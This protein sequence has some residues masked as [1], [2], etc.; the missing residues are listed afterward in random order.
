MP[1]A[2]RLATKLSGRDSGA[3]RRG[4]AGRELRMFRTSGI[5]R[6]RGVNL[7]ISTKVLDSRIT[8]TRSGTGQPEDH[9]RH[10][11][12]DAA[13]KQWSPA[14]LNAGRHLFN[15][16]LAVHNS[17]QR[18]RQIRGSPLPVA[19]VRQLVNV[20]ERAGNRSNAA[21]SQPSKSLRAWA[22]RATFGNVKTCCASAIE[23]AAR[24][25]YSGTVHSWRQLKALMVI[26]QRR[27]P[28]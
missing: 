12:S 7:D 28:L 16:R 17:S 8:L 26:T 22:L 15:Q 4:E 19:E 10:V 3:Q 23:N 9:K 20:P 24:S 14:K 25:S 1:V 13:T 6:S 2:R 18:A 27:K 11:R 5:N 21:P